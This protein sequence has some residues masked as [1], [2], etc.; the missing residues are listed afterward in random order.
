MV[1]KLIE[2]QNEKLEARIH[3]RRTMSNRSVYSER[4]E[5]LP[6]EMPQNKLNGIDLVE[7]KLNSGR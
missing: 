5:D 3:K 2:D 4:E 1:S 7:Y 6:E